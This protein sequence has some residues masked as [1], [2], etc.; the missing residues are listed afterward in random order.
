MKMLPETEWKNHKQINFTCE[1]RESYIVCPRQPAPG[2]PWV[3]RC[4]FFGAFDTVDMALLEQGYHL[5]YHC[6]SDMYGCPESIAMMHT[7]HEEVCTAFGL[8]KK[9]ILF[10]FSR[11]GLYAVN[12]AAEYPDWVSAL[13]LDA[14]VLDIRTWPCKT[15]GERCR[16]E[17]MECYH[18]TEETLETFSDNPLDK[19]DRIAAAGI[20][21]I[22]V[23]GGSDVD[24]VYKENGAL[25]EEKML[26]S[27]GVIQTIVKPDCGHHPHSL[28]DPTPV[29][30]FLNA[31]TGFV[32]V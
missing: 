12:Y 3:W 27:G 19:A 32:P 31:Q 9:P 17:C 11:G 20:P 18:L 7:F 10:G 29:V 15:G 8:A 1:E 16:R 14:P 25:F 6:V 4:E 22:I 24:V 26:A 13:Y 28:E 21:V 2:N 5:A 30:D 23:A